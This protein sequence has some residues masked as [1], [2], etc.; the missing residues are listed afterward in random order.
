MHTGPGSRARGGGGAGFE[1]AGQARDPGVT[2]GQPDHPQA[3]GSQLPGCRGQ[4]KDPQ[5]HTVLSM[6]VVQCGRGAGRDKWGPLLGINYPA[7]ARGLI[8]LGTFPGPYL[9][10]PPPSPAS[11]ISISSCSLHQSYMALDSNQITS[12]I[13]DVRY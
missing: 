13:S 10:I 12:S 3:I 7:P 5:N 2:L 11:S 4:P 8:S 9:H 1:R 6:T